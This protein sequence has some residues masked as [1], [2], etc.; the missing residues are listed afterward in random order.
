VRSN[1]QEALLSAL[2][3]ISDMAKAFSLH[4]VSVMIMQ[5]GKSEVRVV[6]LVG[7]SCEGGGRDRQEQGRKTKLHNKKRHQT[8][9]KGP[10]L[11]KHECLLSIIITRDKYISKDK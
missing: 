10:V 2:L 7:G 3:A 5:T 4:R 6:E 9:K 8:W 11:S 1:S